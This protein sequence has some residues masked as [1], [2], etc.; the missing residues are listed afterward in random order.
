MDDKVH[1]TY[2]PETRERRRVRRSLGGL[3][4]GL[5][6]GTLVPVLLFAALVS[7][8]SAAR[9]RDIFETGAGGRARAISTAIDA[10]L[11][12]SVTSLQALAS[13]R[14]LENGDL[15]TFQEEAVRVL[16]S[17]ADWLSINLALP[18]GQQVLNSL[19]PYGT[20]L[21]MVR[22]PDS[23]AAVLRTRRPAVGSVVIGQV[24]NQ[25]NIPVRVP[26]IRDGAVRYVLS[27]AVNPRSFQSVLAKQDIPAD[28]IG[29]ILDRTAHIVARTV[30]F[31]ATLGRQ[32]GGPDFLAAWRSSPEGTFHGTNLP[33]EEVYTPFVRSANTGWTVAIAIPAEVVQSGA[34]RAF[35]L[36]AAGTLIAL[37]VAFLFAQF[38]ARRIATPIA[39]LAGAARSLARGQRPAVPQLPN[40]REFIDLGSAFEQAGVALLARDEAQGRFA[41]VANN[42]T[43]AIFLTDLEQHCVFMN[44]AA[45]RM[46]GFTFAE[47]KQRPLLDVVGGAQV[48][49]AGQAGPSSLAA[50]LALAEPKAGEDVFVHRSGHGFPVAYACGP[51]RQAGSITGAIVE[52]RDITETWRAEMVRAELL[53][54]QTRARHEAEAANQAKDEFLAMLGHELRNPLGAINNAA[55]LLELD[56]SEAGMRSARLVIARQV[57]HVSRLVDDL[58]DVARVTSGK[59]ALALA[60]VDL[61]EAARSAIATLTSAGKAERR[62]TATDL[63]E[64]WVDADRTRLEQ[65]VINLIDNALRYTPA[66]GEVSV[67]VA[68]DGGRAVLTVRDDGIGI[69]PSMLPRIF[70]LFFQGDNSI[71]R[72]QGGLGIG[73]TLVRRLVELHGGSVSVASDGLGKGTTFTVLLPVLAPDAGPASAAGP[74]ALALPHR[75]VLLID[76]NDDAREMMSAVLRGHG[77][78]VSGAGDGLS[79][80]DLARETDP[81]IALIDIG[82]PG[83]NGYEVAAKLR[84]EQGAR[85]PYLVAL[86]GYGQPE[87]ARRALAAGFDLHLTKPVD[88]DRLLALIANGGEG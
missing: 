1:E 76:D 78:V 49:P 24:V 72:T 74:G 28:W 68:Q 43:V 67:A 16:H 36:M 44:P 6:V 80:I 27:A 65:I 51:I 83:I 75:R 53:E 69:H 60:P 18:S 55:R 32:A 2:V 48:L 9:E 30:D 22:D 81:E 10:E 17:Q 71:D 29:G 21:G 64:T 57:S 66:G 73:L 39:D 15:K 87:D 85:R 77:H 54:G 50:A 20:P 47:I 42:A 79:G 35:G 45:E 40:V 7:W 52:V 38:L 23:L 34:R 84:A 56:H 13:S 5:T 25:Y 59:I 58:L 3:L 70:D 26:I 46:T 19:R 88:I 33:G 37:A 14:A 31:D 63:R 11:K 82:L 61:A 8:L 41:A 86:T 4:L 12:G 62:K